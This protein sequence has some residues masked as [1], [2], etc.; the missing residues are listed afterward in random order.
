MCRKTVLGPTFDNP[1]E[2]MELLEPYPSSDSQR[3]LAYTT[4]DQVGLVMLPIDGNPHRTT[5]L[6]GQAGGIN[7]L[8]TSFD[9]RYVFTAGG[10]SVHMWAVNADVFEARAALGGEGLAPFVDLIEGG[11]DGPLYAEMEEYFYY[12]QIQHQG[13]NT[14][15][16]RKVR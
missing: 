1:I 2:R 6:I 9:G 4:G 10:P 3:L 11:R 14:M 5:V 12:A 8:A 15:E 16:T 13:I 7:R